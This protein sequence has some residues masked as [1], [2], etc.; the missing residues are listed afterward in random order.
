M[1]LDVA[2]FRAAN[3]EEAAV[4]EA[5]PGGP[6]GWPHVVGTRKRGMF[7]REPVIEELGPAYDGFTQRGYDPMVNMGTLEELLTG[8]AYDD[9]TEEPRWGHAVSE[10]EEMG[11][12]LALT[13]ALQEAL[14]RA[15]DERL[16]D[17]AVP[18]SRTE[19]LS[20]PGWEDVSVDEHA[21]FLRRL[22]DL[23]VAATRDGQRLYCYFSTE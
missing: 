2:F 7:R 22:R 10:R 16:R 12:V 20:M 13:D 8:R 5:R 1:S 18:W 11:A 15:S 17:V 21:A 9:I 19:E 14:S 23:A 6:L 3:D 4:A